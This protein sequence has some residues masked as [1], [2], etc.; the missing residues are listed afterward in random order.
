MGGFPVPPTVRL[1]TLIVGI[2][3]G[4]L[5][6]HPASYSNVLSPETAANTRSAG[7]SAV[8]AARLP[9]EFPN[10]I[11]SIIRRSLGPPP[12]PSP[13]PAGRSA[14]RLRATTSRPRAGDLHRQA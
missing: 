10:Q 4:S 7:A 2:V 6:S 11:R 5:F 9:G 8:R 1:A 3:A 12:A 14:H 13:P